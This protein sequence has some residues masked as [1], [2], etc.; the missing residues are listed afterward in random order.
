M[1][2]RRPVDPLTV[3][4]AIAA[5]EE[6][7]FEVFAGFGGIVGLRLAG[8]VDDYRDRDPEKFREEVARIIATAWPA[9][10]GAPTAE[11]MLRGHRFRR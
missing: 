9:V 11:Q 10:P 7:R 1:S 5:L 2:R 8:A 4:E 3:A 6:G